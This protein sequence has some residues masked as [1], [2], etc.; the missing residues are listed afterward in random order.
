MRGAATGAEAPFAGNYDLVVIINVLEH[1]RDALATL[2]NAFNALKPGG[3]LVLQDRY[4]DSL[5]ARY[6]TGSSLRFPGKNESRGAAFWDVGHPVQPKRA[7]FTALA[8]RF[9]VVHWRTNLMP[10][11]DHPDEVYFIGRKRSGEEDMS[12]YM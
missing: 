4:A 6:E 8:R 7:V 11:E 3:H 5:W 10:A 9:D 2:Q 1:C 12:W